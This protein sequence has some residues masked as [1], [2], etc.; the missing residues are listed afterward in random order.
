SILLAVGLAY[1]ERPIVVRHEAQLTRLGFWLHALAAIAV[2]LIL[3][4]SL[5]LVFAAM[6]YFAL[7][8]QCGR[9]FYAILALLVLFVELVGTALG[10]WH[11]EKNP[12]GLLYATNPPLSAYGC[13]AIADYVA[14]KCA[15]RVTRYLKR[16][17][18]HG[19]TAA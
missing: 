7:R 14:M 1:A 15:A 18:R 5:S 6:F 10:C 3:G 12:F 8:K 9:P 16:R 2:F 19:R 13:Y 4:D 11:W 17:E